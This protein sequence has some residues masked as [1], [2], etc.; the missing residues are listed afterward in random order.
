EEADREEAEGQGQEDSRGCRR[1]GDGARQQRDR[2]DGSPQE[3]RGRQGKRRRQEGGREEAGGEAS[4]GEEG[5]RQEG[6]TSTKARLTHGPER[7]GPG[8]LDRLRPDF[9]P[10]RGRDPGARA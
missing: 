1:A 5:A 6:R 9:A 4:A 7:S 3:V 8:P 10:R 2:P